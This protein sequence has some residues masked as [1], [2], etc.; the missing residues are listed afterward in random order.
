MFIRKTREM[1]RCRNKCARCGAKV[2]NDRYL[3][4]VCID[5]MFP[6]KENEK[7]NGKT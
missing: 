6:L 3:C 4:N 2:H 1:V 5:L 7:V